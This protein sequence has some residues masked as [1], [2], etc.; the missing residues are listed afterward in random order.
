[1]AKIIHEKLTVELRTKDSKGGPITVDDAKAILGWQTE[2]DAGKDFGTD[3]RFKVDGDKVRLTN[4]PTNRPFRMTL[5][6]RYASEMFRNKWALN[7]ETIIIDR[8]GFIQSAQHRLVA[9]VLAEN[10]RKA[11]VAKGKDNG[12][13]GPISV[14]GILVLGISDKADVVDTL[15]LGQKRSLGDVIFRNH[16]FKGMGEK[17]QKGIANV[18][19]GATRLAWLRVGGKLV[20]DAP[21]FPHSEALDFIEFHPGLGESV[22]F[23]FEEDG[24]TGA[25]GKRLSSD[26]S[27]AY[28]AGLHYLMTTAK[29]NPDKYDEDGEVNVMLRDKADEFFVSL[30]SGAGLEKGNPILTLKASLKRIDASG[31]MGRDEICGTVIKAFNLWLDGKKADKATAIKVKRTKDKT[32]GKVV[33]A[34]TPRLG[35]L[36]IDRDPADY[37]AEAP[38]PPEPPKTQKGKKAGK[39]WAEGDQA[40]VKEEDGEHWFGTVKEVIEVDPEAGGGTSVELTADLDG[41]TYEAKPGQLVINKPK[42]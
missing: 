29:T 42:D 38:A 20:S 17:A 35:G 10:M 1:M 21:H 25:D 5:A 13:R 31:A 3:Y 30:A 7:G 2:E 19:A 22:K 33:L 32:T 9:I 6:K 34:E 40:W 37:E 15:D 18:L 28:A 16:D 24:G 14:E 11:D 41:K 27:L 23:I 36:D 8:K 39:T 4:N 12:W 26:I